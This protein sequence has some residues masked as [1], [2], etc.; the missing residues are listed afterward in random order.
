MQYPVENPL[1]IIVGPTAVG[2]TNL[3]IIIAKELNGEIVSADS[4]Y[5]Y[6]GMDIGTAKP[7]KEEMAGIPHHLI[8]V[9]AIDSPW[10]LAIYKERAVQAIKEIQA[11]NKI[12]LLVGGTG[13]YI[14]ALIEGWSVPEMKPNKELR[15]FLYQWA[16]EIGGS[17]LHRVLSI[18]DKKAAEVIDFRNLRRIV[19]AL[20]VILATGK[21]FSK[22]RRKEPISFQY[23]MIGLTCPRVELF[24]RINLR[25]E[26]MIVEGFIDEVRELLNS[27]LSLLD[28]PMSAIGYLEISRYLLGEINL[29]EAITQILRRTKIFVRR[30]ANWF[31]PGDTRINWFEMDT[32][33]AN[34]IV[35]FIKDKRGWSH[36]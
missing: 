19:R 32:N 33:T 2:K 10:S 9:A 16:E 29:I 14:R 34:K 22:L 35:S 6:K 36:E 7:D 25:I 20:E 30:Q 24:Q 5:L 4:R 18:I 17:G 11:R 31:K 21:K 1:V 27:G 12:P 13:Q 8:D 23:K 26:K 15:E 3:S 28:S